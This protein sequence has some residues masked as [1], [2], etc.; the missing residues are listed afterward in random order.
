MP[1]QAMTRA[2]FD[3]VGS[4]VP[5][6]PGLYQIV[7]NNGK[8]L[9]VGIASNLRSRLLQHRA[10]LDSC[11]QLK[12]GGLRVNPDD[13]RSKGSILAKHLYYDSTLS[14]EDDLMS[15][16]GRRTFLT[17]NCHILFHVTSSRTAARELE[18]LWERDPQFV[19]SAE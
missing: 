19:M 14:I 18:K 16:T 12:S 6:Q 7:M 8:M 15:E 3:Q 5:T 11:L 2:T 10:S 1:D 13:V 9:K 17:Q 4:A